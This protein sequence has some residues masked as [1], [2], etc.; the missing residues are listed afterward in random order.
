MDELSMVRR[1]VVESPPSPDVVVEGRERLVGSPAVARPLRRRR[2]RGTA[3]FAATVIAAALLVTILPPGAAIS[4]GHQ[5]PFDSYASA[6]SVLLAAAVH[7]ES[8]PA[9]GTYWHV[10]SL[11]TTTLPQRFG[12]TGDGYAL[13]RL[14]LREEWTRRN[15]LAW[16]GT[17]VWVR[18]R[19]PDDKGAWRRDGMPR[20]WCQGQT[21]TEPPHPICLHTA[22]GA[23]ALTRNFFPF[24]VAEG[25]DL[26]FAQ[27][28]R[29]PDDPRALQGWL[30]AITRHDLDPSA[31]PDVV[32]SNVLQILANLLAYPPVPP[33][34]RAAAYR[35]LAG[36]PGVTSIG[37]VRDALG[38]RGIG[39]R[40]PEGRG[41]IFVPG[42]AGPVSAGTLTRI[43]I[44][45]P[46]T[47]YVLADETSADGR[48]LT[49]TVILAVGWT[50]ETP[51]EPELP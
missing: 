26:T 12:R 37:R 13:E 8:A 16:S 50:N 38:R 24:E 39:I 34:V 29:L 45:D 18:P 27:L 4:P 21:D 35:A 51:R 5:A 11:S 30:V 28:Q 15:G 33:G 31:S 47:S 19:T 17:R 10:R 20:K 1:L 48:A 40:V 23:A 36:M 32:E 25:H 6:R 7:A 2:L 22:P 9:S 49:N 46:R 42:A 41:R 44:I 3:A 43:L 14:S